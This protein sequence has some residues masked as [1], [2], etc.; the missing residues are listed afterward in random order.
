MPAAPEQ[1]NA[2][3]KIA[4]ALAFLEKALKFLGEGGPG[5]LVEG[6]RE[7]VRKLRE[8][9]NKLPRVA[10]ATSVNSAEYSGPL[11]RQAASA[12]VQA[13]GYLREAAQFVREYPEVV[14]SIGEVVEYLIIVAKILHPGVE[15]PPEVIQA[16]TLDRLT[17]KLLQRVQADRLPGGLGDDADITEFDPIELGTGVIEEM[18]HTDDPAY[19]IEVA[20]D[21]LVED[22]HYYTNLEETKGE[23][24]VSALIRVSSILDQD[25]SP[26]QMRG[27][28]DLVA[29]VD[30]DIPFEE[31]NTKI[32]AFLLDAPSQSTSIVDPP[33]FMERGLLPEEGFDSEDSDPYE[34]YPAPKRG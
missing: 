17:D 5:T 9:L 3:K 29:S 16:S 4:L 8:V 22:P 26:G 30:Q 33:A 6:L 18:E 12:I 24:K 31:R 14:K 1:V 19:A 7:A 23:D 27:L 25:L 10:K 13:I 2:A 15:I 20:Q 34:D 11:A 21:H 32:E 28:Q